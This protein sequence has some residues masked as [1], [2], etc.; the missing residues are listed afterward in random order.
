VDVSH[1]LGVFVDGPINAR[2]IRSVRELDDEEYR[3]YVHD[4]AAVLGFF[5]DYEQYVMVRHAYVE[6][7]NLLERQAAVLAN[8]VHLN[9][10]MRAQIVHNINRRLRSFFS[11]FR[12]FL[13]YTETKL[14]RRYG[15]DS[16][17]AHAFKAACSRQFDRS[18]DYRFVYKLRNYALHVNLPLNAMSLASGEGEFDAED[19][20]THNRFA[21]KVDRDAL[22]NDGFDWGKHVRPGLESLPASFEL[23]P[24]IK[25]A[26]FC[27]EKIHVELVCSKLA[28]EKRAAE[29]IV[30]LAGQVTE[31][32][33]P[34]VLRVDGPDE[35]II[36]GYT[37]YMERGEGT[38]GSGPDRMA[39]HIGWI[40]VESAQAILDLP[41]PAELFRHDS[42]F[43]D[44]NSSTPSGEPVDLPF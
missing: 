15:V 31:S 25:E 11:E 34:C 20:D 24:I 39:V 9:E 33:I 32:G 5:S 29:R 6:Y 26:M 35:D 44:I 41:E 18:F 8:H 38:E 36:N 1:M 42:F 3:S 12:V 23:N 40:P 22:L 16:E 21:V 17:Q 43:L 7:L 28:G 4:V 2:Q 30:D 37:L 13:D 27:L 10:V 19:P 14:K